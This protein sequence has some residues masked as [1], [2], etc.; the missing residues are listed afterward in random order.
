MY[1]IRSYYACRGCYG[2]T[3]VVLDQAASTANTYANAGAPALEIPDKVGLL[4]R[5]S[6]PAALISKK[7]QK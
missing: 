6:L 4:N 3:D 5:F 2:K 7:V 1:A